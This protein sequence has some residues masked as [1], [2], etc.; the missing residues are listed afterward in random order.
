MVDVER[1]NQLAKKAKAQ[2]LTAEEKEEQARLRREYV[3]SIVG[4]LRGQLDNAY[5]L[6]ENGREVKLERK[7]DK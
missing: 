3:N 2:G 7:G 6:D 1:I 5:T 4:N